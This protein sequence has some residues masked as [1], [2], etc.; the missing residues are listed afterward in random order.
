MQLKDKVA[1]EASP[2]YVFESI[3]G[4][5]FSVPR[6]S[7]SQEEEDEVIAVLREILKDEGML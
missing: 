5:L 6:P 7:M 3:T 1:G 2:I 4:E